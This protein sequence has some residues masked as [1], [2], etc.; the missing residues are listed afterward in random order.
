MPKA[1]VVRSIRGPAPQPENVSKLEEFT[2]EIREAIAAVQTDSQP[3]AQLAQQSLG[4][5]AAMLGVGQLASGE[6]NAV[7]SANSSQQKAVVEPAGGNEV[8]A[9]GQPCSTTVMV[10]GALTSSLAA[11]LVLKSGRGPSGAVS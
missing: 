3:A 10:K 7:G 9:E 6:A 1:A 4:Q 11:Q 5:P 2:K 8:V